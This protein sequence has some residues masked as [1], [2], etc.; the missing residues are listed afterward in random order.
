M[1][2]RLAHLVV[3]SRIA[4]GFD[5]K[6]EQHNHC[7]NL[8]AFIALVQTMPVEAPIAFRCQDVSPVAGFPRERA[9]C[10]DVCELVVTHWCVRRGPGAPGGCSRCREPNAGQPDA[11]ALMRVC[12]L[13]ESGMPLRDCLQFL[14]RRVGLAASGSEAGSLP[15]GFLQTSR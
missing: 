12:M 13:L 11:R 2:T 8:F 1:L 5:V 10:C 3:K 7:R 14:P 9:R 4:A 6:S 15:P